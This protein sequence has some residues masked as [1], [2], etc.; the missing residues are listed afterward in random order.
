M[1]K[2]KKKIGSFRLASRLI[3]LWMLAM[4]VVS[5]FML[6]SCS[7]IIKRTPEKHM[8]IG[9]RFSEKEN[10]KKAY[11]SY[12][13]AIN[14]NR[15]LF[16]AYWERGLVDVKLDSMENAIDD[17]GMY[18]ES[19]PDTISLSKA[20]NE[21]GDALFRMGYKSDACDDWSNSCNLGR[22]NSSCQ[23]FRLKCK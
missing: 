17:I 10:Y 6:S 18:I 13:R 9:K 15:S 3:L 21:R 1:T 11:K 16:I 14:G 7:S 2:G 5:I 12:T 4:A 8:E 19:H 22:E 20:Y 23:K